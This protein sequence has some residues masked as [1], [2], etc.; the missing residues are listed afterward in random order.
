MHY[1]LQAKKIKFN[2]QNSSSTQIYKTITHSLAQEDSTIDCTNLD[3]TQQQ[4]VRCQ[5][6][7]GPGVFDDRRRRRSRDELA[8]N[9]TKNSYLNMFPALNLCF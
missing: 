4:T 6:L 3:G 5:N 1:T 7:S 9:M 2:P 8:L